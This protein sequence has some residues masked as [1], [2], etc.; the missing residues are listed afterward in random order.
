MLLA[1]DVLLDMFDFLPRITLG[2]STSLV[3]RRFNANA[4]DRMFP[5]GH[6]V[7]NIKFSCEFD[8]AINPQ[9]RELILDTVSL[10][11]DDEEVFTILETFNN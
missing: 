11:R 1:N 2:K 8:R 6:V 5:E 9:M 10:S 3:D 7:E 4:Q